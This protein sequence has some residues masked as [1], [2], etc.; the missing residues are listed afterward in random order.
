MMTVQNKKPSPELMEMMQAAASNFIGF[1]ELW[2]S[3]RKKGAAE[4][5]SDTELQNLFRPLVK[6][7][8]DSKQIWYLFHSEEH[9]ERSKNRYKSLANSTNIRTNDP[10]KEPEQSDTPPKNSVP[11]EAGEAIPDLEP[12]E[13]D[14]KDA[15]ISFLKD[16]NAQLKAALK[17]ATEFK[18]ASEGFTKPASEGFTK[19]DSEDFSTVTYRMGIKD[20]TRTEESL[21]RNLAELIKRDLPS[22]R[23][24]GWMSVEVTMRVL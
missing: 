10:K 5:F 24:R 19:Q 11:T 20:L 18:P 6:D 23:N 22:L 16:D 1:G 4:G 9:K 15:E 8:L 2:G 7:K 12:P 21:A 3:I 17:K 13:D 14:P